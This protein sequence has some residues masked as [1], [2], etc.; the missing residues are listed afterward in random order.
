M[1]S[2]LTVLLWSLLCVGVIYGAQVDHRSKGQSLMTTDACIARAGPRPRCAWDAL[3]VGPRVSVPSHPPAAL[4]GHAVL[5]LL[6]SPGRV[7]RGARPRLCR[8]GAGRGVP[9]GPARARD[10]VPGGG[11]PG[12]RR[13]GAPPAHVQHR[14]PRARRRPAGWGRGPR[15][16]AQGQTQGGRATSQGAI[17]APITIYRDYEMPHFTTLIFYYETV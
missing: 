1:S 3:R 15:S 8:D 14:T 10:E 9:V 11:H 6:G 2:F 17:W 7:Q 12:G 5:L 13:V 16:R 4:R